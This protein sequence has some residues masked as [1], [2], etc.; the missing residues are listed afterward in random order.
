[1]VAT[2]RGGRPLRGMILHPTHAVLKPSNK[3]D[4]VGFKPSNIVNSVGFKPSNIVNSVGFK[5]SN[6]VTHHSN[7]MSKQA[8]V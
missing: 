4:S 1:M 8:C 7:T 3:V 6:I 5:P 2:I